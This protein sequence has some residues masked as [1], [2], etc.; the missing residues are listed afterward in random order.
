MPGAVHTASIAVHMVSCTKG[1]R[2]SVVRKSPWCTFLRI[3]ERAQAVAKYQ[4]L[5]VELP[6]VW[7]AT[8]RQLPKFDCKRG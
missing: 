3:C 7:P 2:S 1:V 4:L 6:C 8:M 5:A